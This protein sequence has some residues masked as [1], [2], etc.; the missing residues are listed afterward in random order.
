[1]D[2]YDITTAG[3]AALSGTPVETTTSDVNG[4]YSFSS[5]TSGHNYIVEAT[6]TVTSSAGTPTT[7]QLGTYV[8]VAATT[9]VTE[10]V[11]QETTVASSYVLQQISSNVVT[12]GE[13]LSSLDQNFQSTIAAQVAAGTAPPID[14]TKHIDQH[15]TEVASVETEA[16][17]SI[18]SL[19]FVSKDPW[20]TGST[21]GNDTNSGNSS[22]AHGLVELVS[23]PATSTVH[24]IL[25]VTDSNWNVTDADQV[26]ADIAPDGTFSGG[27]TDGLYTLTGAFDGNEAHGTWTTVSSQA[28]GHWEANAS[29]GSDGGGKSMA[30]IGTFTTN[31]NTA[32]SVTGTGGIFVMP[33]GRAITFI[34][35]GTTTVAHTTGTAVALGTATVS[36]GTV[37]ITNVWPAATGGTP[38][39][40]ITINSTTGSS[41]VTGTFTLSGVAAGNEF[42]NTG[43][44]R[45]CLNC[46]GVQ[47]PLHAGFVYVST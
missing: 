26:V 17:K 46:T 12:P 31:A 4:N 23:D 43:I 11:D 7:L 25:L 16:A 27:S 18:A 38:G 37:T 15:Q 36:T 20:A 5:T 45:V 24:A 44:T 32:P 6:K 19:A 47:N 2:L 40:T 33:D 41:V 28:T 13:D 34:Q 1:V 30:A 42:N 8:H 10:P 35:D 9:P 39:G 21:D 29:N 22:S 3:T 14:L